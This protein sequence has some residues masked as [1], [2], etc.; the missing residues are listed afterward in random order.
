MNPSAQA[1]AQIKALD[2]IAAI[3][4]RCT[5]REFQYHQRYEAHGSN[6]QRSLHAITEPH[7]IYRDT[8][9][10]LYIKI[11]RFQVTSICHLSQNSFARVADDVRISND[12]DSMLAEVELAESRVVSLEQ[13]WRD[14]KFDEETTKLMS[15]HE[16]QI[17]GLALIKDEVALI[18]KLL[19]EVGESENRLK[20]LQWLSTVDPSAN[21]NAA[22]RRH[23]LSTGD[24]LVKENRDFANWKTAPSSLI[25]LNGKGNHTMI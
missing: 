17:E 10:A 16:Q 15:R 12:W 9:K 6:Y 20:L 3:I 7:A 13:Q 14:M 1:K 22:R 5:L 11:L 25:W 8:L 4:S 23:A 18:S 19:K 2:E 21:Y 24:W